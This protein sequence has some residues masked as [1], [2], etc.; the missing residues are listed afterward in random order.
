MTDKK[1][2]EPDLKL[3]TLSADQLEAQLIALAEQIGLAAAKRNLMI[4]TAESCTGGAIARALT[5]VSGSSAWFDSG[6]VTYSNDAK[7]R[8][9]GVGSASLQ[10]FGAVSEPVVQAMALGAIQGGPD[11][12]AAAVTGVAGPGGGSDEKPVG[13]VWFGWAGP[14]QAPDSGPLIASQRVCFDGDRHA[15]RLQT[16][17][18]ALSQ[19]KTFWL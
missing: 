17:I 5:E 16:A 7:Q 6:Y 14:P 9:L 8:M 10:K 4:C 1:L 3:A 11:R 19:L 15:V 12:I 13:T 2:S 18:H